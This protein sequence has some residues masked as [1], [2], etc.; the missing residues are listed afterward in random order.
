MT[1]PARSLAAI[2]TGA[3]SGIGRA[4]ALELA[5]DYGRLGL[6]WYRSKS[7][8]NAV[9][10]EVSSLG[11]AVAVEYLDLSDLEGICAPIQ[12]LVDAIG[13]VDL[14]VNNA[15]MPYSERLLD[16][17][18]DDLRAV[19]DVNLIGPVVVTQIIARQIVAE[20]RSGVVVNVTSVLQD[21]AKVGSSIYASAKAGLAAMTRGAA[22]EWG[23]ANIRVL[24]VAPGEILTA[25]NDQE[26]M[27]P[28]SLPR[29]A[30]P[31]QRPG[32]P[33]EV[34]RVIRHLA[35]PGSSYLTGTTIICD[36]GMTLP[37]PE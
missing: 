8:I 25:M 21:R 7:A 37:V 14:L 9:A 35:D 23:P 20:R 18:L 6:T 30:I 1:S 10:Q 27:D 32:T 26:G 31:L 29:T 34:A 3:E 22:L 19:I 5:T 4:T 33:Q 13:P 24:A 28:F 11:A 17:R 12:R 16:C 36:G 15:A 2:I